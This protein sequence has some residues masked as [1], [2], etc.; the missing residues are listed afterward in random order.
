MALETLY[1]DQLVKHA[2]IIWRTLGA[3]AHD[4]PGFPGIGRV[5]G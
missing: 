5:S 1:I 3:L 4:E 2:Q